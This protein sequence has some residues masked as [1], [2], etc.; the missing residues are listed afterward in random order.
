[1]ATKIIKEGTLMKVHC[2]ECG[3]LFSYEKEDIKKREFS[4][5]R[6]DIINGFKEWV[7]CPQCKSEVVLTQTR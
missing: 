7:V 5:P 1:M 3:C 6:D 2:N 4:D